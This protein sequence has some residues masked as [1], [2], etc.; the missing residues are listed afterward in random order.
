MC[1]HEVCEGTV[2]YYYDVCVDVKGQICGVIS[3]HLHLPGFWELISGCQVRLHML[4]PHTEPSRRP[5][6]DFL[7]HSRLSTKLK[8]HTPYF[9]CHQT[10]YQPVLQGLVDKDQIW[11]AASNLP[12]LLMHPNKHSIIKTYSLGAPGKSL[13]ICC[14]LCK[15]LL[16]L[17]NLVQR[18]ISGIAL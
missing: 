17:E 9:P 7:S 1:I 6:G 11:N 8:R 18:E 15:L 2:T 12:L 13:S 10:C 16:S 5:I 4:L 3:Y 14:S